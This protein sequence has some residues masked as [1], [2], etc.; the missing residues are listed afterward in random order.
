MQRKKFEPAEVRNSLGE[1]VLYYDEGQMREFMAQIFDG[2]RLLM[3]GPHAAFVQYLREHPRPDEQAD[4]SD[5][6]MD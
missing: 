5:P 3:A 4:P 1:I 6:A 2:C